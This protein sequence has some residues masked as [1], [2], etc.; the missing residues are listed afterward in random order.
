MIFFS[1]L[2]LSLAKKSKKLDVLQHTLVPF[3]TILTKKETAELLKTYAIRLVDLPRIYEDDPVNIALGAKE[4][5]VLRII[6]NSA[7]IVDTVETF[8]FVVLRR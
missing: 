2:I 6:R 7:T 1:E 3:H 4:G 5:D 8:R